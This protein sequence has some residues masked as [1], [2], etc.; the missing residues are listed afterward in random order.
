MKTLKLEI[1]GMIQGVF[2]R[3]FIF[4]KA[5]ELEL[6]GFVRNLDNGNVE[7]IIEGRDEKVNQMIEEAKKSPGQSQ[8]KDIKVTEMKHQG[9]DSF[10]ILSM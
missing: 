9:M 5:N 6:K 8:V 7:V 3:R 10:K 4:E 1:S 2:F